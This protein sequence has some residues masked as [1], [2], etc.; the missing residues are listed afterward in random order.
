MAEVVQPENQDAPRLSADGVSAAKE[1]AAWCEDKREEALAAATAQFRIVWWLLGGGLILLLVLPRIVAWIDYFD[2][3]ENLPP[4]VVKEST[5]AL[6]L[7]KS[8]RDEMAVEHKN[9]KEAAVRLE[10][11]LREQ[12]EKYETSLEKFKSALDKP[13]GVWRNIDVGIKNVGFRDHVVA[14]GGTIV[15]G[16]Y[17]EDERRVPSYLFMRSRDGRNWQPIRP[18]D[19]GNRLIGR[20]SAMMLVKPRGPI[21]AAGYERVDR[22]R[23]ILLLR[24]GGGARWQPI[25]PEEDG[26]RIMGS[27][28]ALTAQSSV[29]IVAGGSELKEGKNWVLFLQ[30]QNNADWTPI[31]P[32]EAGKRIPGLITALLRT[33]DGG[34]IAGGFEST[35]KGNKVLFLRSTDLKNWVAVRPLDGGKRIGGQ[36]RELTVMPDG[37]LIAGGTEQHGPRERMLILRSAD[38]IDWMPS[39]PVRGKTRIDGHIFGIH[40]AADGALI[41]TGR[42]GSFRSGRPII[43]RSVDEKSWN[44]ISFEERR[45]R[46]AGTIYSLVD[47]PRGRNKI[48]I[49]QSLWLGPVFAEDVDSLASRILEGKSG[50]RLVT[51]SGSI[52][53]ASEVRRQN[54]LVNSL[55][56]QVEQQKRLTSGALGSLRRQEQAIEKVATSNRNLDTALRTAEPVRQASRI[57]TRVAI[58][59]LIIFLVQIV[60]NRYRYLQR[61]AGFYQARA[62][63]FRMLAASNENDGAA[64]L[65]NVSLTDMIASLSPDAIGFDKA[66]DPPAHQVTSLLQSA[67]RKP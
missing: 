34:L 24:S 32:Q 53:L 3:P 15:L 66:P 21:F 18:R 14:P 33:A 41:A 60:V 19:K 51:P 37:Q 13:M 35:E 29:S 63:A 17:E 50:D 52:R 56:E 67:I 65:Q 46:F 11:K 8:N 38:G 55:T 6:A 27:I 61:L 4:A 40:K 10:P 62:Q 26:K 48:A 25:K 47:N 22:H 49:G 7:L 43:L 16:G 9:L 28:Y 31:R 1:I 54:S 2:R 12:T 42:Q 64:L 57:A 20:V 39:S 44:L 30:T 23:Y 36:I 45:R 59:A 58:V 5:N